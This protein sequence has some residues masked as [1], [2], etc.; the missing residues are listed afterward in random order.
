[1]KE[2]LE[3]VLYSSEIGPASTHYAG[4]AGAM[5]LMH[6]WPSQLLEALSMILIVLNGIH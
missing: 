5:D 6:A 3:Q 1:L 2:S 4:L